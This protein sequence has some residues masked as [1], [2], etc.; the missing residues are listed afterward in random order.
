M[1]RKKWF[2]SAAAPLVLASLLLV[3]AAPAHAACGPDPASD[4]DTVTC[5]LTPDPDGFT[6]S[7]V[8]D[9]VIGN[10]TTTGP[11]D[12]SGSNNTLINNGTISGAPA[13]NFVGTSTGPSNVSNNG[14]I[15]GNVILDFA[16][17][18]NSG[19]ITGNV[20][21][22]DSSDTLT[23]DFANPTDPVIT[24]T[25]NGGGG[26]NDVFANVG[27]GTRSLDAA[28]FESFARL[29]KFGAG[30]L[31]LSSPDTFST[32]T[33]EAGTL[34]FDTTGTLA[35]FTFMRTQDSTVLTS[36]VDLVAN[37]GEFYG[38]I[39]VPQLT[40]GSV[41][42]LGQ[43][44]F[45]GVIN[46]DV[47]LDN[48]LTIESATVFIED[49]VING[50]LTQTA[51]SEMIFDVNSD[52]THDLLRVNG[53]VVA[54][55]VIIINKPLSVPAGSFADTFNVLEFTG[56]MS[57]SLATLDTSLGGNVIS[58]IGPINASYISIGGVTALQ[59]ET[60][61]ATGACTVTGTTVVCDGTILQRFSARND[62]AAIDGLD[63]T[64][65][66]GSSISPSSGFV[67]SAI[68]IENDTTL[69]IGAGALLTPGGGADGIVVRGGDNT[70]TLG[71]T[72]IQPRASQ[73]AIHVSG[74]DRTTFDPLG[75]N[76]VV[77]LPGSEILL[78]ATGGLTGE[79]ANGIYLEGIASNRSSATV[80]GLIDIGPGSASAG[81]SLF[82]SSDATITETG[83]II[84]S[85]K[86][87]HGIDTVG[88]VFGFGVQTATVNG[89]ITLSGVQARGVELKDDTQL[90]VGSSGNLTVLGDRSTNIAM[91]RFSTAETAGTLTASGP[92]S[93]SIAMVL[94]NT[95]TNTGT[96]MATGAAGAYRIELD[97]LLSLR[98]NFFETTITPSGVLIQGPGNTLINSGLI[99]S[100]N[101]AGVEANTAFI[102]AAFANENNPATNSNLLLDIIACDDPGR[103]FPC[104]DG[105]QAE[106]DRVTAAL[107][108]ANPTIIDN[109]VGGT[110]S[111]ATFSILGSD[112]VEQVT[113]AGAL[114]N[115]VSLG[116]GND[117]LS[118]DASTGTI[119]GAINGGGG[120][121]DV[122]N[123]IG[124]T[125]DISRPVGF[126][127]INVQSGATGKGSGTINGAVNVASG[128]TVAPGNSIGT[129]T[130]IGDVVFN[131]GSILEI[132]AA[133]AGN[134]DLWDI[135]GSAAIEGGA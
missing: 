44:F 18:S 87:G 8:N 122:F 48:S 19:L 112:F 111:G 14:T 101:G 120:T 133:A 106:F 61:L 7:G 97:G 119:G 116:G 125:F 85:S 72:V 65:T 73:D 26:S 128:A 131:V 31:Q 9:L 93:P 123:L 134:A 99:G 47:V 53:D 88:S 16:N 132:E 42:G 21:F 4:G 55:G 3:A 23:I 126:E 89:E 51:N 15:T 79:P 10:D 110:I 117:T 114:P 59:I 91:Q 13:V 2:G 62:T 12:V 103:A 43:T 82:T 104:S 108:A 67:E 84:G 100:A 22:G 107:A 29:A 70:V 24:G 20:T 124:G 90:T 71:G 17:L 64:V 81:V 33:V 30:T 130:T 35:P 77:T 40:L 75:G 58:R 105:A 36:P 32:I 66:D 78:T 27:S 39:N 121:G 45:S 94:E 60:L 5:S 102:A 56:S 6:S 41:A 52:G 98:N 57:G 92:G 11:F 96:V 63:I 109:K 83:R 69:T 1:N 34:D 74:F 80:G 54:D 28:Q 25:V 49:A 68:E 38:T 113:N 86:D 129:L 118:L 95:L 37:Q 135:T 50:N 76:Q 127:T 46:G 115:G